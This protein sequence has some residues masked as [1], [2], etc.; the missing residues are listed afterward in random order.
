MGNVADSGIYR[1]IT[2][3]LAT[4]RV[5]VH[6]IDQTEGGASQGLY[7]ATVAGAFTDVLLT[8]HIK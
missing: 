6:A 7:N 3:E 1:S 2:K 8:N 5:D 4:G